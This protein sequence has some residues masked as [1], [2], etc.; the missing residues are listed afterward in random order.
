MTCRISHDDKGNFAV[1]CGSKWGMGTT[2]L[3]TEDAAEY[4][5]DSIYGFGHDNT[6]PHDFYP[7]EEVNTKDEIAA[8]EEAKAECRCGR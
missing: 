4:G 1:F 2:T 8:W 5:Q 7:D 3:S 6:D